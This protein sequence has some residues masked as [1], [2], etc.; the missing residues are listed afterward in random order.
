MGRVATYDRDQVVRKAAAVFWRHGYQ[1]TGVRELLAATGCNR[2]GLY[3]QFGGKAGLFEAALH[4]YRERYIDQIVA[5]LEGPKAGLPALQALF[6]LRLGARPQLG[7]LVLNTA[8]ERQGLDRRLHR[9]ACDQQARIRAGVRHCLDVARRA[10]D[11][12]RDRDLD[13]LTTQ[14]M[15]LLHGI[16]PASRGGISAEELKTMTG[17]ALESMRE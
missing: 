13:S 8:A 3:A 1:Q 14:L 4:Y 12:R 16:G 5:L 15:T 11:I 10:G 7:C 17:Q 9:I 6:D 2:R